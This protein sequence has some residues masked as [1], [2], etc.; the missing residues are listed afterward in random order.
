MIHAF[1]NHPYPR[2]VFALVLATILA[3]IEHLPLF[4]KVYMLYVIIFIIGL[5]IISNNYN[6]YGYMILL[7]AVFILT[8]CNV[9]KSRN[10][11]TFKTNRK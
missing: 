7:I 2:F 4:Q 5:M 9:I 10:E 1:L 6:D 11:Q 8:Y 3:F